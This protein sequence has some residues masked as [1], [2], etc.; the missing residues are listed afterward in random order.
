MVQSCE[1]AVSIL[2]NRK[3]HRKGL[4]DVSA[5]EPLST[6]YTYAAMSLYQI[7]FILIIASF[8]KIVIMVAMAGINIAG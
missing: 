5:W 3:I 4:E 7:C 8:S 6:A 2:L 1:H